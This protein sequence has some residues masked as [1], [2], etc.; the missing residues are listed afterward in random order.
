M[1][2]RECVEPNTL[3]QVHSRGQHHLRQC[4]H[5]RELAHSCSVKSYTT[6]RGNHKEASYVQYLG[7][8][9][10]YTIVTQALCSVFIARPHS[11][12]VCITILVVHCQLMLASK[13]LRLFCCRLQHK[14]QCPAHIGLHKRENTLHS[15]KSTTT[16]PTGQPSGGN[17]Q[18][19]TTDGLHSE[20]C[21]LQHYHF[22]CTNYS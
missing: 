20:N 16:R 15:S 3:A 17:G 18:Q 6:Q 4:M 22:T 2:T 19:R 7:L 21:L 9:L 14:T 11:R 8:A 13:L 12:M 5:S 10:V 1:D